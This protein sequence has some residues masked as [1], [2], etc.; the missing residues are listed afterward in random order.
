[1]CGIVGFAGLSG[2]EAEHHATLRKMCAAIVHR[3]PNEEGRFHSTDVSLGMRRLSVMDPA[4]GQQ[5]MG[6][7]DGTI[8]L[9]FNGEIYNH[10]QLRRDL[11]ARGHS[12]ATSSDTEVIVHL[13]E[14][15][16]DDVVHSLRGMFAFALW[17]S[18]RRRLLIARDRVGIKPLHYW[19]HDGGLA[20]ASELRSL[21]AMPE[22][23][24]RLSIDAIAQ[25]LTFG[26]VPESH[27]IFE[28]VRKLPPGHRLTWEP[29]GEARVDRYWTPE[30]PARDTITD[31]E[32]IEELQA[33]LRESVELHLESDVPLGAFLSG[34]I[35]SSTVVAQMA[36]LVPGR[37]K[38]F[39][40]GFEE[41]SHNEAPHAAL[42][43]G[44]IGT[45]HTELIVRPDAD[46][47]ID[48]VITGFDEPFGDSS[49]LP[50]YL[51]SQMAREHVTV[52][53][54]GD[55]GDELFG[56]YTRY[57]ELLTRRELPS[58]AR[59]ALSRVAEHLPQSARG[60]N[61]LLDMTRTLQGRYAATVAA[62]ARVREGGMLSTTLAD[63][64]APMDALLSAAFARTAGRDLLAQMTA[65]DLV[66]YLPG[67]ILTKVDKTSMAASLEARVPLLDHHVVEFAMALPSRLKQRDGVGKWVLREAIRDLVPARVLAHPKQGFGV[68]LA[69]W[70]R[71]EIGHRLDALLEPHARIGPYVDR[72][73]LARM[74]REHRAQRRD[75]SHLLWRL[76]ALELWLGALAEGR[77]AHASP[78]APA[79]RQSAASAAVNTVTAT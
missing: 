15:L 77:L 22:F 1:M 74:V 63:R 44:E 24:P 27:C 71:D 49:A 46:S 59:R 2:R 17:D 38:T 47:L 3:G 66:T 64:I 31:G 9:V 29:G 6:N 70:F 7:E 12:I 25:Y 54:S 43:A 45:E 57:A 35:D 16:G 76:V 67:D 68:P 8:Q 62:P 79:V 61:R 69:R 33:L 10:R 36:R 41:A 75:H 53:L 30:R 42:V 51:V 72:A 19:L 28:G 18:R 32:A 65:V 11:L 56:G 13:Y 26:Y 40:I 78:L 48:S 23:E 39:S 50:T 14:E 37:V 52:A 5:P 73:T 20:F 34:G 4:M 55:G 21:L 60:R 58:I